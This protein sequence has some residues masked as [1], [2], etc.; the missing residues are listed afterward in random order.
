MKKLTE[1]Q[2]TD[3]LQLYVLHRWT[4]VEFAKHLGV[5][6]SYASWV[7]RGRYW[8]DILRPEGF[9]YPWPDSRRR[10][11]RAKKTRKPFSNFNRPAKEDVAA[12]LHA[13]FEAPFS[14]AELGRRLSI[15]RQA[16]HRILTKKVHKELFLPFDIDDEDELELIEEE[17]PKLS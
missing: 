10:Q 11:M 17:E 9:E 6:I 13:Y 2:V 1:Q 12:Q 5:S 14:A 3:A 16:A 8:P 4:G 7:L 15:S